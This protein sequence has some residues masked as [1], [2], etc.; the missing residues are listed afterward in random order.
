MQK[1]NQNTGFVNSDPIFT[2]QSKV[3]NGFSDLIVEVFGEHGKHARAVVGM[4]SIPIGVP[5]MLK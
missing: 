5:W 4:A 3:V 1:K 2:D